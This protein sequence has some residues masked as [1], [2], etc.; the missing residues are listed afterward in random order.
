M[1]TVIAFLFVLSLA[2]VRFFLNHKI[3][4]PGHFR[5]SG[6]MTVS[7]L[8]VPLVGGMMI[9]GSIDGDSIVWTTYWQSAFLG[10]AFGL[11]LWS[12]YPDPNAM[13]AKVEFEKEE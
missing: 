3:L 7:S 10:V 5:L 4:K 12:L 2:A 1:T 11:F 9:S 13:P 8:F 6:W